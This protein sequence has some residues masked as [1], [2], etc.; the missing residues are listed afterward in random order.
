MKRHILY[1]L[2]KAPFFCFTLKSF[3]IFLLCNITVLQPLGALAADPVKTVIIIDASRSM[4]GRIDGDRKY[5]I[6][7]RTIE[8]TLKHHEGKTPVG[9]L[10]FGHL[11]KRSCKAVEVIREISLTETED[12][13]LKLQKLRPRNRAPVAKAMEIAARRLDFENQSARIVLVVDGRDNCRQDPC[14]TLKKLR[15]TSYDLRVNVIGFGIKKQD[16]S[17]YSCFKKRNSDSFEI[18][19]TQKELLAALLKTTDTEEHSGK[20][21][22]YRPPEVNEK[23]ITSHLK[24]NSRVRLLAVLSQGKAPLRKDISWKVY[25]AVTDSSFR[26]RPLAVSSGSQP[27]I[28]LKPGKYIVEAK[29]GLATAEAIIQ[30]PQSGSLTHIINLNAGT[31]SVETKERSDGETLE[32]VFYSL[33]KL[34]K[35][36]KPQQR[37]IARSNNAISDFSLNAG[38]YLIIATHGGNRLKSIATITAGDHARLKLEMKTG[39]LQVQ[40]LISGKTAPLERVFYSVYKFNST[41]KNEDLGPEDEISRTAASQPSLRLP[42]GRYVIKAEHDLAHA[43][44]HVLITPGETTSAKINLKAATLKIRSTIS[45]A[46]HPLE[47]RISYRI[48]SKQETEKE[49]SRTTDPA[50]DYILTPGKYRIIARYGSINVRKEINIEIK[51]GQTR[52]I[53]VQHNAGTLKVALLNKKGKYPKINVFWTL[54]DN[55]NREIWRTSR[56]SPDMALMAGKYT[57]RA[58]SDADR[59]EQKFEIKKGKN[60]E[61]KLEA[62]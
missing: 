35:Y 39:I 40:T 21:I 37:P 61:I 50:K 33:Y 2:K 17:R 32:G 16:I 18:A 28:P 11:R 59:Y 58:D 7:T 19:A 27:T 6:A 38:K 30:S 8:E 13:L 48:I 57:I 9:V 44:Q 3:V 56:P 60:T 45:T 49:I 36:L 12:S 14:R 62:N 22:S 53:M 25:K 4:W 1:L 24:G 43:F 20:T 26:G 42:A 29:L 51:P 34:N 52:N 47:E 41:I 5:K 54:Y 55:N 10:A 23:Q 31:L 46:K 15:K